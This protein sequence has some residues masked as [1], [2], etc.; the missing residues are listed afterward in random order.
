MKK[1]SLLVLVLWA[2]LAALATS[3]SDDPPKDDGGGGLCKV[4]DAS[5]CDADQECVQGA[6]GKPYCACSPTTGGG[7]EGGLECQV[8]VDGY[9]GC[10]C[11]PANQ[12]GC[13]AGQI[14][15][16]VQGQ[17]SACFPP[18]TVKG[19]V[20][21]LGTDAAIEGALVV[22]RD[23][24]NVA[25]SDV[26]VSGPDGAYELAVRNPRDAD[27]GLLKNDVTLRADAAG[28]Q[29]FP[30]APRSAIPFD[31]S[32]AAG[33]PPVLE[34]SVTDIGLIALP[35][36]S[37]L[38]SVSG[39]VLDDAAAGTLVVAGGSANGGG[40][41]GVAGFDGTYTVFNVPAGDVTVRGYKAGLQLESNTATVVADTET[42]GVD[43]ASLGRASSVVSGSIQI[44]NAPGG[45]ET[46]VILVVEETFVEN[47]ASGEAP[48]GLRVAPVS[49]GF[50]IP[51]VPDGNYVVLA[52]FENDLLVRDPDTS[53]GGT[54]IVHISVNGGNVEIAD[55]FKVTEAL[56][57]FGPDNEEVVSG[58]PTFEWE[59]DS[60]EDHYEVVVYDAFGILVWE[61]LAVPGVSGG[62]TVSVDYAG[63]ALESGML[64][65]FRAT[66]IKNNGTPIS[67]TE[68]LRGVFLYQ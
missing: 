57:V 23:A 8:D 39:A 44:V 60:S 25:V 22:A 45:S 42:A 1:P 37:G 31:T 14:C 38:G 12:V 6:D 5:T 47:T 54:E 24:N 61:D 56:A 15:E 26:A 10:F 16:E 63:P 18:V 20:F 43:L 65:Q 21:D 55:G 11:S 9:P 2:L 17:N 53:I 49:G 33:E 51:D 64:Y 68:D 48:P 28:Y 36:D 4:G 52:A 32:N 13:D 30:L 58:T 50:S 27:G 59:D 29:T 34:S 67:R 62:N 41:S 46:S 66:S 40:V 19:R 3:C 35:D 7:C